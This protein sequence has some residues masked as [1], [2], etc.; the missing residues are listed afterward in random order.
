MQILIG[1][2]KDMTRGLGTELVL[3]EP[4]F[5]DEARQHALQMMNYSPE[6]L[7]NMLHISPAL[8]KETWLRYQHFLDD[9]PLQAALLA[10]TGVVFKHMGLAHF[11]SEDFS[12]A[13]AHLWI[14]SFLYGL[15]RPL[16]GIRPYRLEGKVVLPQYDQSML[17]YWR[18]RL[19][20]V[21]IASIRDDDGLLLDLASNEMRS[22][23][24]WKRV[25]REVRVV[26]PEFL[27]EKEGVLKQVT[28]YAKMCRGA[29][30]GHALRQRLA[31]PE[32]LQDFTFEGFAF[33]Y[34]KDAKTPLFIMNDR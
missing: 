12:Y 28:V 22:F 19:T 14:T 20:D 8:A 6:E 21:F 5:Q 31:L 33:A 23:F 16:D 25:E 18:L 2:A 26:R 17:A 32:A 1:C 27:V 10:Y 29:M 13:Q 11:T 4:R 24:D 34:N 30:A 9:S 15:L 3:H 7:R